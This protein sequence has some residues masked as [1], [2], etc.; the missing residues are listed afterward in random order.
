[1][2]TGTRYTKDLKYLIRYLRYGVKPPGMASD[3]LNLLSRMLTL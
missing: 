1:M 3:E 2:L